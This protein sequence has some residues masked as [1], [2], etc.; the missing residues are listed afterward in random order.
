[1]PLG[2]W[3]LNGLSKY[4][5]S[6]G[7]TPAS[8]NTESASTATR[9]QSNSSLTFGTGDFTWEAWVYV[10]IDF[11]T[12]GTNIIHMGTSNADTSDVRLTVGSSTN[13]FAF[14]V[15]GSGGTTVQ[16]TT[17]WSLN[18]WYHVALVRSS[19]TVSMYVNGTQEGST[20]TFT[21]NLAARDIGIGRLTYAAVRA[22]PG[23]IDEVRISSVA[24]YTSNFTPSTTAFT[25]DSDTLTL[26]HMDNYSGTTV[27][28]DNSSGR[29]ALDYTLYGGA[30][31]DTTD[32]KF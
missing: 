13:N 31:I 19:G 8:L 30:F 10:T 29:S 25:D 16:G 12:T 4:V 7:Y 3:R 22:M 17:I 1:M 27:Y 21:T 6:V 2:A 26:L 15:G 9:L 32:Y 5:P 14:R 23:N 11:S 24:R 18:T 28:D 20:P